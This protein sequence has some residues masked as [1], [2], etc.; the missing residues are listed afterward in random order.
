MHVDLEQTTSGTSFRATVCIVGGGIAGLLLATR[1]ASQN[2]DV[3][4]LEAGGLDFEERSQALYQAR[5]SAADH[6][7]TNEGR[8]RTFGGSSTRWGGQ[9]LPFTADIFS[10]LAG[11][12]A[13]HW[14]VGEQELAA[15]YEDVEN[16]LGVDHL[17]YSAEL[18]QALKH[19][20]PPSSADVQI[21]F[22]KWAPFHR[23]NLAQTVGAEALAHPRIT[24]FSH[25]NAASLAATAGAPH[26]VTSVRVVGYTQ[27]EFTFEATH[28][29]LCAGTVESS[30]LLLLSPDI[31][32]AHDQVGRYLH[33]H[34]AYHAAR[35]LSPARE[36]AVELLGPFFINN[37]IHSCKLEASPQMRIRESLLAV[38]AHIVILE[39]DDSG[40]AAIRNL[41]R[42]VQSGKFK[43]AV[44]TNLVPLLRGLGDVARLF[45]YSKWKQRRAVSKRAKLLLNI[46][47]EQAPDAENRVRLSSTEIDA[48]GLPVTIVDWKIGEAERDTAARYAPLVRKYLDELQIDPGA[49]SESAIKPAEPVLLDTNHAMGGLRMGEDPATS[50]VDRDL[51]VHGVSNLSVASCAVFPSGSSSNPTF[52][53]M[54][55]TLRLADHLASKLSAHTH[56]EAAS[57]DTATT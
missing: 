11:S 2:L 34:V 17:P 7:G 6:R 33:D 28:F 25:A 54:A 10:P 38:M 4:L 47:V 8:F 15:Y 50:V 12:P 16:I 23:R 52:T 48:L 35:F 57:A 13:L 36:R 27:R 3:H 19:S 32:N 56:T 9:V 5:M 39:P 22:A 24:V 37:T 44:G 43:Q 53:L 31:P 18:L 46:D 26:A 41:L 14:T 49:W 29:V 1:L 40:V 30:R 51:T 45:V 21:R 42:S 20:P 55:L